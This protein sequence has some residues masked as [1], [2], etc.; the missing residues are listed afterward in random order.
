DLVIKL[1]QSKMADDEDEDDVPSTYTI[2][3]KI[4]K[5]EGADLITYHIKSDDGKTYKVVWYRN[6]EGSEELVDDPKSIVGKKVTITVEDVE[7][8]IPKAKGYYSVKEIRRLK[9]S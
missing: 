5:V 7:C 2:S 1:G 3:G 9:K 4:T 6:F 8:Y